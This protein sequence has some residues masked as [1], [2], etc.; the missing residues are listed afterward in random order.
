[1]ALSATNRVRVYEVIGLPPEGSDQTIVTT[2]AHLPVTQLQTWE[3]TFTHSNIA[4]IRASID[5]NLAAISAETQTRIEMYLEQW[6]IIVISPLT[7]SKAD[8]GV[9]G[10]IVNDEEQREIIRQRIGNLVGIWVPCGGW[11]REI[12]TLFTPNSYPHNNAGGRY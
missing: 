1:M 12:S 11:M 10:Q 5:A 3:P 9:E 2:L 7:I 8:N 6:E 4:N